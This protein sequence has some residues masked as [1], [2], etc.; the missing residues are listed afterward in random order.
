MQRYFGSGSGGRDS[1]G[2]DAD[3]RRRGDFDNRATLSHVVSRQ[4]RMLKVLVSRNEKNRV[5][6]LGN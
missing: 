2:L 1:C 6:C 5:A 3:E 4:A